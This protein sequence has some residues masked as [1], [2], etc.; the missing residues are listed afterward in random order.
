MP[1]DWQQ[2][3]ALRAMATLRARSSATRHTA[4]LA[5]RPDRARAHVQRATVA[6]TVLQVARACIEACMLYTACTT[7]FCA[8]LRVGTASHIQE[9][10]PDPCTFHQCM[11]IGTCLP[12]M[13]QCPGI[14]S[15][16]MHCGRWQHCGDDRLR[17]DTR[18]TW[19]HDRIVHVHM[20]SGVQ[21]CGLCYRWP[22]HGLAYEHCWVHAPC[23]AGQG[24]HASMAA[25]IMHHDMQP[26]ACL[27]DHGTFDGWHACHG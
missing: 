17:L 7:Q 21:R 12:W 9:C 14:G 3:H 1:W 24:M 15:K 26:S 5:A 23:S 10:M 6:L 20:C 19:R 13:A 2:A 8:S 27:I 25:S 22:E 16:R 18:H 4:H 11:S